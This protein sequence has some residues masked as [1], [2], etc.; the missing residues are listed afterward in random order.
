MDIT[1][2]SAHGDGTPANDEASQPQGLNP[3]DTDHA[4]G[5]QQ[6]EENAE[7]DPPG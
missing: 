6:A 7:D 3:R 5:A 2:Q 1:E 4:T